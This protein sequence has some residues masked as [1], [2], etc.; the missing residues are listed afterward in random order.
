MAR[1]LGFGRRHFLSCL[2]LAAAAAAGASLKAALGRAGEG[3]PGAPAAG[4]DAGPVRDVPVPVAPADDGLAGLVPGGELRGLLADLAPA[5]PAF[6]TARALHAFRLWGPDAAFPAASFTHPFGGRVFT[7]AELTAYLLDHRA[8]HRIAPGDAP[9]LLRTPYGVRVRTYS[10]GVAGTFAGELA[11]PDDLLTACGEVGLPADT[12]LHTADGEARV[13]DLVSDS[14]ARFTPRQELEWTAEALARYLA[15]RRR[16]ANRFGEEF[17]FDDAADA[18]LAR[19]PGRGACLGTHVPYALACLCRIDESHPIL[20]PRARERVARRLR[21]TSLLLVAA[22]QGEGH[23]SGRWAPGVRD[24]PRT[25]AAEAGAAVVATGHHLEWV[26]LA[27]PECRPPRAVIG[28][29]V[30]GAFALLRGWGP[31]DR[32]GAYLELSH[33][34][35]ALCLL[36]NRSPADL[37]RGR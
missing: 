4:W 23:W 19:A 15:P 32:A 18:L 12:P 34:A 5:W 27:P 6:K 36:K 37:V 14:V 22:R 35:R 21:E 25:P 3:R 8:Y 1:S 17:S 26:A 9:L 10:A 31:G 33:L 24:F 13:G 16:W 20:S 11:H 28:D 7:G 2:G 30:R 29:A